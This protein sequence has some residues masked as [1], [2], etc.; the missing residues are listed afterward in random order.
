MLTID[1]SYGEGSGQI[2]R[3]ALSLSMITG[4]PFKMINIRAKRENPHLQPQHLAAILAAQTICNAEVVGAEKGSPEI[5]FKP[6]KPAGG[7]YHFVIGTAGSANLVLQTVL[8]A[9]CLAGAQSNIIIE[10]GT[11]N[12][13]APPFEFI[14]KTFLPLIQMMGAEVK[15]KLDRY[16]FYPTGSGKIR[17]TIKPTDKFKKI[18]IVERGKLASISATAVLAN[19]PDHI[20][21]RELKILKREL[22]LG[23]SELK[24]EHIKAHSAG[25]Y[26]FVTAEFTNITEVFTNF[27]KLGLRAEIVAS[28]LAKCVK[29]YLDSD[30]AVDE[31]LTDQL[32]IYIALAGGGS[33]TTTE[34]ASHIQTNI[35]LIEQ[36]LPIKFLIQPHTDSAYLV[37]V[38]V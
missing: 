16:G 17:V 21:E 38:N 29:K 14:Q 25:N 1:G 20:A 9:L 24:I 10:G 32:L 8:P 6:G 18:E 22:G 35:W 27:G 13:M 23:S 33:L 19:L 34:I 26:L 7:D 30:A 36:F 12:P 31:H 4:V 3:S 5:E 37:K 28:Q 2:L 11:H 15:V